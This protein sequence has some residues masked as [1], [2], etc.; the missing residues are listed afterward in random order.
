MHICLQDLGPH[1]QRKSQY[2]LASTLQAEIAKGT[3]PLEGEFVWLARAS[4]VGVHGTG[5]TA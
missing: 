3:M 1:L 2:F 5:A 4:W